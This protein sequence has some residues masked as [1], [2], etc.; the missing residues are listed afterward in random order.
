MSLIHLKT[1]SDSR[2]SLTS[3]EGSLD[4]PFEIKRCYVVHNISDV[5]GGHAHLKTQQVVVA[6]NGQ[7]IIKLSDGVTTNKFL[8]DNPSKGLLIGPL[9]WIDINPESLDPV[10]MV[11]ASTHYDHSATIRDKELFMRLRKSLN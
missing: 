6:V 3:I 1:N 7:F 4:I 2:G 5:R 8:L 11:L 10:L 9:T